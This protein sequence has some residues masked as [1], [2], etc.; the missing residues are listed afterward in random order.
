MNSRATNTQTAAETRQIP[1]TLSTTE[2]LLFFLVAQVGLADLV[3][4]QFYEKVF[5]FT[6]AAVQNEG[7][8]EMPVAPLV[9]GSD[10]NFYGSTRAGGADNHGTIFKLSPAGVL[11]TLVE[12]TNDGPSDRGAAPEGA[13]VEGSDGN[14]YGTT[15][16]GGAENRGTIFKMT[17]NGFLTTLVEFSRGE[18]GPDAANPLAGLIQGS[19]GNFYGTTATGGARGSGTAFKM[20]PS[21]DLTILV[22]FGSDGADARPEGGLVEADDGSFY[23]TTRLGG[24]DNLGT[25]FKLT[26]SGTVTT[27]VEFTGNGPNNKG[28]AP[29]ASLLLA[30]DGNYYGTT[31]EGGASDLGTVFRMTPSG[32]LTTLAELSDSG[33][34][35]TAVAPQSALLEGADGNFYGTTVFGGEAGAG[36]IFRMTPGGELTTLLEFGGE[37][38]GSRPMSRLVVGADGAFYGTTNSTVFRLNSELEFATLVTFSS[39]PLGFAA[40]SSPRGRLALDSAGNFYG[41]N[42]GGGSATR[43]T[44][45][46]LNPNGHLTTLVDFTGDGEINKGSFPQHGLLLGSDGNFFGATQRGSFGLQSGSI[47][48][49]TPAGVLTTLF[50]F[51]VRGGDSEGT[52][53]NGDLIQTGDGNLYGTAAG[54]GTEHRGTVFKITPSGMLTTLVNFTR[55]GASNRGMNPS[56]GLLLAGDGHFYGTTSRGGVQDFGTVFKMSAAGALTTLVEFTGNGPSDKGRSPVAGLVEGSDGNLYGTT[57]FGG[58]ENLGTIFRI[59]PAGSLTTIVEFS[60]DG[61][62]N[63][64]SQPTTEL[65]EGANGF[66]YGTTSRGGSGDVG[67]VFKV[68]SNGDLTTLYDFA[69]DGVEGEPRGA[70]IF[71]PHGDLYGTTA[72]FGGSNVLGDGSIYRLVFPGSPTAFPLE[73]EVQSSSSI[74]LTARANARNHETVVV[75]EYWTGGSPPT[76]IP[77]T[78]TLRGFRT[79]TIGTTITGI[80]SGTSYSYRFRATNSEGEMVSPVNEFVTPHHP[81]ATTGPA[82]EIMRTSARLHASVNTH[83]LESTVRFEFGEDGNNFPNTAEVANFVS[84]SEA[85]VSVDLTELTSGTTYFYRVVTTNL[86]GTITGGV[87]T[88]TTLTDPR[89]TIG[90]ASF[91]T[92]NSAR[93][94]GQVNALGVEAQVVFEFGTDGVNFPDGV[95]ATPPS[96]DGFGDTSVTA[97]LTGLG[98]GEMIF[99][100]IR[101]TSAG[102][103]GLS[104][105]GSFTVDILS[106]LEQRFPDPPPPSDG[107]AFVTLSPP[108]IGGAW[109]FVG[110]KLWRQPGVPATG[111][112][113][114]DRE[115]EFRPVPGFTQPP[116]ELISVI[117]GQAA[118]TLDRDYTPLAGG[119]PTGSLS[120]SIEPESITLP[121]IP[122]AERGQWRLMGE[123]DTAWRNSGATLSDLPQGNYLIECKPVPLRDT[124]AVLRVRVRESE[125]SV[126]TAIYRLSGTSQG[127]EPEALGFESISADEDLPYAYVGQLRSHLGSASGFVVRRRVVATAAH[128]VFDDGTLEFVTGL[129]WNFQRHRSTHEPVPQSPRGIY[130]LSGYADARFGQAPGEATNESRDLDAAALYFLEDA[131]RG[132]ASG[133]LASD[134]EVNEF[135]TSSA[136]KTLV[137]YPID[138]IPA[139]NQGRMHATHVDDYTFITGFGRTYTTNGLTAKGGTSGGP[140]CVQHGGADGK[141]FPA[142]IHLGGSGGRAVVRAI[143]SDIIGLLDQASDSSNGGG[144]TTGYVVQ[145]APTRTAEG[146]GALKVATN[147]PGVR[148]QILNSTVSD[149][150]RASGTVFTIGRDRTV[151]V[152]FE[153]IEGYLPPP[154]QALTLSADEEIAIT[155][156]YIL[157]DYDDWVG[158][159]DFERYAQTTDER[160]KQEE[161]VILRRPSSDPD[162]DGISNLLEYAFDLGPV[163]PDY[164]QLGSELG[165]GGLPRFSDGG[166]STLTAELVRRRREVGQPGLE[167]CVEFSSDGERWMDTGIAVATTPIDGKWERASFRDQIS[168]VNRR[169]GRVAIKFRPASN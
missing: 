138:G 126:V 133:F 110:E 64:G 54:G 117:S 82:N 9:R 109:R 72:S 157:I 90:A 39:S 21:G 149:H 97:I 165:A 136:A 27:L 119:A 101:A 122:E 107:F 56:A 19:N 156:N 120:V 112:T 86:A 89:A 96:V 46:K 57:L 61:A 150:L 161:M 168:G 79:A 92:S 104:G 17:P 158:E 6:D 16:L 116:H 35:S 124:P 84:D 94:E 95:V 151:L 134:A 106:G 103:I 30:S 36:T 143:D 128:A 130:L 162:G 37:V 32:N 25:V 98:Q 100:R 111:L 1:S 14:L 28:K 49:M 155:G 53:P 42:F 3:Q 65:V 18:N 59:T 167:Y 50:E 2:V 137:G 67:T 62:T 12:F 7:L 20:T 44:I 146:Q 148:W 142:A 55:N 52:A 105:A 45:F 131:G 76:V 160:E 153:P 23:G 40:G 85:P 125:A 118:A 34:G 83:G 113:T 81:N 68:T 22:E 26:S 147:V 48:T 73:P 51:N 99:Y 115:V 70:L 8:G 166:G 69:N 66:F 93:V 114:G 24:A 74:S 75:L 141:F 87:A 132:G 29:Y 159:F 123:D 88:F 5:S 63:K 163:N 78:N 31:R 71:S 15:S 4:A 102:G 135:L 154:T 33:P 38:A 127:A 144:N 11:T 58:A 121:A 10:G 43:G 139:Q 77:I 41:T 129:N 91:V 47:F 164:R 140:L 145:A 108:G 13:L 60:G 152:A 169:F 80:T